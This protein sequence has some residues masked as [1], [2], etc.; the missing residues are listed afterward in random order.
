MHE[1]RKKILT[2]ALSAGLEPNL[3]AVARAA[4]VDAVT[5]RMAIRG[6]WSPTPR[7]IGKL[8]GALRVPDAILSE[9]LG[10]RSA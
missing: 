2:L 7:T 10:G 4:E 3:K 8:A 5:L 1:R 9:I 6:R